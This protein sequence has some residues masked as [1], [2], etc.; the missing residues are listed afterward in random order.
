[1]NKIDFESAVEV[2]KIEIEWAETEGKES[3][4]VSA[5]HHVGYVCGLNQAVHLLTGLLTTEE[6]L[7][8]YDFDPDE[9]DAKSKAVADRALMLHNPANKAIQAD[10]QSEA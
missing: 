2:I 10:C 9:V 3:N 6:L 5:D 7:R 4:L 1:M 8:Y